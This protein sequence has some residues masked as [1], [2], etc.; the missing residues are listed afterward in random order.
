MGT[1]HSGPITGI[2]PSLISGCS[3]QHN[4]CSTR[5]FS[6]WLKRKIPKAD[7]TCR[8]LVSIA[9]FSRSRVHSPAVGE[10]KILHYAVLRSGSEA[11]WY[12]VHAEGSYP[13]Y[14]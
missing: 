9:T 5:H 13:N 12:Q 14:G 3:S 7:A 11:L 1:A 10:R 8:L 6:H 4:H 2:K